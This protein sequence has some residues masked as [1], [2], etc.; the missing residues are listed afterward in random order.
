MWRKAGI[1]KNI[2]PPKGCWLDRM[3]ECHPIPVVWSDRLEAVYVERWS[4]LR[5]DRDHAG[6]YNLV[7]DRELTRLRAERCAGRRA[8]F[9][10]NTNSERFEKRLK[11]TLKQVRDNPK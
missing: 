7:H 11:E 9:R 5:R 8:L 2:A 1:P 3:F 4:A 6:H 10:N